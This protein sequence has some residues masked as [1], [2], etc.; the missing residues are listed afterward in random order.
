MPVRLPPLT[1]RASRILFEGIVDYAGLY[2]PAA[3]PMK[4]AVRNYAHYRGGGGAWLLGRFICPAD[5]LE[6][7]SQQ[8]DPLLPRDAGAI[9]W[10]LAAIGSGDVA[11]DMAAIAAFNERHRVCFDEVGAVVDAYEVRAKTVDDIARLDALIPRTIPTYIEVPVTVEAPAL[12]AA[13]GRAGRRAKMRMGG[14]TADAFPTPEGV[15]AFLAACVAEDV[16]AKATAGLHHALRGSY[17]LTYEDGAPDGPMFGFVN[18]FLTAAHLA[19]GGSHA[20]A[21]RL[22]DEHDPHTLE[23]NDH[24][25]AWRGAEG[26][27]HFDRALLTRVREGVVSSFGSCS[28][29]EPMGESRQLGFV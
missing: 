23:L 11:A 1:E 24:S 12:V 20:E 25:I 3:L 9:P 13:I 6:H 26:V 29:T 17:R 28:F 2:P 14:V 15:V 8:A 16:Q 21:L 4:A 10:R 5:A 22:L 7:F 27:H 18:V 19:A